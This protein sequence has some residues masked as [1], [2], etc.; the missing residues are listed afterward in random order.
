MSDPASL[1]IREP[2][3]L[4]GAD[5]SAR[6]VSIAQTA[7]GVLDQWRDVLLTR[8]SAHRR[9]MPRDVIGLLLGALLSLG[10][11]IALAAGAGGAVLAHDSWVAAW[12]VTVPYL[13]GTAAIIAIT[14]A[15]CAIAGRWWLLLEIVLCSALAA[16]ISLLVTHALHV[17]Q[18][19]KA[20]PP[21]VAGTMAAAVLLSRLLT[22]RVRKYWWTLV[23]VG[24]IAEVLHERFLLLGAIEAAGIGLI[25]ASA[26]QLVRGTGD[27]FPTPHQARGF[28]TQMG[29]GG[30][31]LEGSGNSPTWGAVR[32][33]GHV[34]TTVPV[35]VDLYGR[36]VPE[37]QFMA[38]LWR[39]LWLRRSTLELNFRPAEQ[40]EHVV[41]ILHWAQSLEVLGPTVLAA[42]RFE[43]GG[44]AIL[45]TR[46]AEGVLLSA[47]PRAADH[48]RH[49]AS[50]VDRPA[51]PGPSRACAP[52]GPEHRDR[53][54]SRWARR[55]R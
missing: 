37:G 36:D 31:S 1:P 45:V 29:L 19:D 55:L 50:S 28:L 38:R 15:V 10:A 8:P 40:V 42:A 44:E 47:M 24:L 33:T 30:A 13:L 46:P 53:R 27:G 5:E 26:A 54:R 20:A 39:F 12:I 14:L 51:H 6:A 49:L 7:R 4:N 23:T 25:V 22:V 43:P 3:G 16:A 48:G 18:G 17:G 35:V 11:G 21:V 2:A 32:F 9:R 34:D 41:G 52:L